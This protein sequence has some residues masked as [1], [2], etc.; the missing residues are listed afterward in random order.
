MA[1]GVYFLKPA[2]DGSF[3]VDKT[4]IQVYSVVR[5][6]AITVTKQNTSK[7]VESRN[8]TQILKFMKS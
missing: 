4:T 2:N 3:S 1:H 5:V 8:N 6:F 7:C